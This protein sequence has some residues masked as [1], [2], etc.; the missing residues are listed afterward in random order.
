VI[1]EHEFLFSART[2]ID[3]INDKYKL[4]LP[5]SDEYETLGGLVIYIHESIPD[6]KEVIHFKDFQFTINGVANNRIELVAL[7]VLNTD[8]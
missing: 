3:Y 5:E 2:E 7:K 6:K 8:V 4:N 1:G